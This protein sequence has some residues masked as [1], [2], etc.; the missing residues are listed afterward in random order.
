MARNR[1]LTP[2]L[3]IAIACSLVAV[4]TLT[5]ALGTHAGDASAA[6]PGANGRLVFKVGDGDNPLGF[7]TASP[8][9]NALFTSRAD[10]SDLR[11]MTDGTG[12]ERDPSWSPDGRRVAFTSIRYGPDRSDHVFLAITDPTGR[13]ELVLRCSCDAPSW[14]PDGRRLAVH[15]GSIAGP[16]GGTRPQSDLAIIDA[17]GT[18]LHRVTNDRALDT[19]PV[20]SPTGEW[21]AFE[22]RRG[23]DAE[24]QGIY[25]IRPNGRGL[26]RLTPAWARHPTWSPDGRWVAFAG[27]YEWGADHVFAVPVDGGGPV[28]LSSGAGGALL[29]VW[30]PDGTQIS[31]VTV[32]DFMTRSYVQ[33]VTV[34]TRAASTARVARSARRC[35]TL[36]RGHRRQLRLRSGAYV[37]DWQPRRSRA[38][39][40]KLCK[41]ARRVAR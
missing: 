6:F 20:W 30:S 31:Y 24:D 3:A 5:S 14:S 38:R 29:P 16:D 10:G 17:D 13:P 27:S 41:R 9:Y 7:T 12:Q 28:R 25:L 35:M 40:T 18:N 34:P 37:A 4:M 26:H 19:Q 33:R 32:M 15:V 36:Q 1:T 39:R 2:S 22:S 23:P 11:R 21:I 8:A